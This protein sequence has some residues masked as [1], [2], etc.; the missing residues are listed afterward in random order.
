MFNKYQNKLYIGG[1][2][3]DVIWQNINALTN[4]KKL[5]NGKKKDVINEVSFCSICV[6]YGTLKYIAKDLN[7]DMESRTENDGFDTIRS[8]NNFLINENDIVK[9]QQF[10][11]GAIDQKG[12]IYIFDFEK[13]TFNLIARSGISGN[14]I[15]F[16]PYN[17]NEIIVGHTNR[18]IRT[19][20]IVSK[21]LDSILPTLHHSEPYVF[22]FH[23]VQPL[24][25]SSSY[26]EVIIWNLLECTCVRVL[27][28]IQDSE[29]QNAIY[30]NTGQQIIASFMNGNIIIWNSETFDMEWKISLELF[31][32]ENI[33][34]MKEHFPTNIE[35]IS[36]LVI[37]KDNT[38]LVYG[39]KYDINKMSL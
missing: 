26:K 29:I 19:Y 32:S 38:Q 5:N 6:D 3:S 24:L 12:N 1:N 11:I 17:K 36:L 15:N 14:C 39:G 7:F 35:N 8:N 28:G 31:E 25:L 37:S 27:K 33:N 13:N 18:S 22:S 21:R 2:K 34:P 30:S 10:K 20:N 16:N 23:P 4:E 9:L